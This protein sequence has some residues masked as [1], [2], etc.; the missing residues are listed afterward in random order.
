[1]KAGR[2][3]GAVLA[4]QLDE[5]KTDTKHWGICRGLAKLSAQLVLTVIVLCSP[6]AFSNHQL[7]QNIFK[8]LCDNNKLA[9]LCIR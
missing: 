6:Q 7:Y 2:N 8:S 1:M 9:L 5:F 4:M 3:N